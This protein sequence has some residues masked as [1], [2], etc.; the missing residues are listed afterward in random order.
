[1]FDQSAPLSTVRQQL[2]Q[3]IQGKLLIGHGLTKDL[4]ALGVSHPPSLCLDTMSYP[5]FA[6]KSGSARSLKHLAEKHLGLQI[7]QP[8]LQRR[9]GSKKGWSGKG[10]AAGRG[11]KTA[12]QQQGWSAVEGHEGYT[13]HD[14]L[15]DAAA[16]MLLYQ[17][18]VRPHTYQG[19]VEEQTAQLLEQM[20]HFQQQ[21]QQQQ[22]ESQEEQEDA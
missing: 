18:V 10:S 4:A 14:P 15:E 9:A 1:M 7:Q 21:Q 13:G 11:N 5:E 16:V 8:R 22:Q 6:S 19:L 20:R 3:L 2:Q 12:R 17:Q